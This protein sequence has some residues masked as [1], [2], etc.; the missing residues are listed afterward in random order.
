[1]HSI[2]LSCASM[3]SLPN[4]EKLRHSR[5]CS[6]LRTQRAFLVYLAVNLESCSAKRGMC[7]RRESVV[8]QE[9]LLKTRTSSHHGLRGASSHDQVNDMLT[10]SYTIDV[11]VSNG[12]Y[13]LTILGHRPQTGTCEHVVQACCILETVTETER[14]SDSKQQALSGQCAGY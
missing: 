1:M 12:D 5:S 6:V 13:I 2:S 11:R 9:H 7:V 10:G 3:M 14:P 4:L 8:T